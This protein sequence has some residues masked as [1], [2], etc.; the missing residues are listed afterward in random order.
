M[1]HRGQLKS[2]RLPCK[3]YQKKAVNLSANIVC[4]L[5]LFHLV[6]ISIP[7]QYSKYNVF[8]LVLGDLGGTLEILD[9]T[10]E[11]KITLQVATFITA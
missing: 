11:V 3:I 5:L 9:K 6:S 2:R 10:G 4:L 7:K 1:A 8:V